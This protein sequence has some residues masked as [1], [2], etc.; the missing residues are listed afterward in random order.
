MTTVSASPLTRQAAEWAV[1]LDSAALPEPVATKA[2]QGLLDTL[3]VALAGS[4]HEATERIAAVVA[5]LA[6][7][8]QTLLIGSKMRSN[9]AQSALLN[10]YAAHVLDFD[11]TH[12]DQITHVNAPVMGAALAMGERSGSSGRDLLAAYAVGLEITSRTAIASKPQHTGGWHTSG[13]AGAFGATAA[14]GRLLRLDANDMAYAIGVASTMASGLRHHRGTMA[15]GLSPAHAAWVG[16]TA[17]IAARHGVTSS[18]EIWEK[19][20]L[21]FF[22][23]HGAADL[24]VLAGDLGETWRMLDWDPKPYP[25]GV[26]IHP[27]ADAADDLYRAGLRP[28]AVETIELHVN[29]LALTITGNPDPADGLR[30]K[31]SVHHAVAVM[32]TTGSLLP[33]H[34]DDAWATRPDI[35]AL[36]DRMTGHPTESLPR[37]E[38]RVVVRTR[39]GAVHER[40]V[41]ARG[42]RQ[43]RMSDDDVRRKYR[44]LASPV[45]GP[46]AT[47]ALETAVDDLERATSLDALL[48][49][50]VIGS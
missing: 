44:S 6:G 45:I 26:V 14:V 24:D 25:C 1:G 15:K 30:S 46:E 49:P 10:A 38:A 28:E 16:V 4:R 22:A 43:R 33:E 39:D 35:R 23:T 9:V 50:L 18:D 19:P 37:D 47:A 13:T 20:E 17:A 40:Q 3:G 21:G 32:L 36:R 7:A 48:A 12:F 42:T 29:P 2:R 31:F 34:F 41:K 8:P 5:E 27:A 11:D